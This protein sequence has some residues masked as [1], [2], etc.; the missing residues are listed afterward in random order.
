MR[1]RGALSGA[2]MAAV[3]LAPATSAAGPAGYQIDPAHSGVAAGTTLAPPLGKRWV[4]RDLVGGH[5]NG[6]TSWPVMAEGR[7]YVATN[8]GVYALDRNGRTLW[9]LALASASLAYDAGRL[10]AVDPRGR[11]RSL[12]ARTGS[13]QWTAK[14]PAAATGGW[15]GPT[16]YGDF[17]YVAAPGQVVG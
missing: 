5:Y 17:V 6:V 13:V 7:I 3:L 11:L 4:R 8:R 15:S 14:L 1:V 2:V 9:S 10:V 16:A 12:S